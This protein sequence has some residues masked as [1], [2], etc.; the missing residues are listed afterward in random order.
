MIKKNKIPK[1][2]ILVYPYDDEFKH[3]IDTAEDLEAVKMIAI[4][5]GYKIKYPKNDKDWR[6][7]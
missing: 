4:A 3:T 2:V 1:Y 5:E 7:E 6:E